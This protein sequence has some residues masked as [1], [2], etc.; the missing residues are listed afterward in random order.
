[1]SEESNT[2]VANKGT[3]S[4]GIARRQLRQLRR[5]AS[6]PVLLPSASSSRSSHAADLPPLIGAPEDP[7]ISRY[8]NEKLHTPGTNSPV[9]DS[10]SLSRRGR[11]LKPLLI[12][13][14]S[15]P[16]L[17]SRFS[18]LKLRPSPPDGYHH[19]SPR[20][21]GSSCCNSPRLIRTNMSFSRSVENSP[22]TVRRSYPG[23]STP[24]ATP[25]PPMSPRMIL[26]NLEGP[27]V[28]IPSSPTID[29][30]APN[31]PF[32]KRR[33]GSVKLRR[34]A[35]G[36]GSRTNT[37]DHNRYSLPANVNI[38]GESGFSTIGNHGNNCQSSNYQNLFLKNNICI[39]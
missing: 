35:A 26:S 31:S 7:S 1:M 15:E 39:L 37:P 13:Q 11:Q 36:G 12:R 4:P 28:I 10:P 29:T 20:S 5:T 27:S 8:A 3:Y 38:A 14:D 21:T 17:S 19:D 32:A 24:G 33:G 6:Q 30:S 22:A 18:E 25:M 2:P 34:P 9:V 16:I 23:P